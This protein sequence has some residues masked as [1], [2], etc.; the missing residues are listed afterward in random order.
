MVRE[1]ELRFDPD[2]PECFTEKFVFADFQIPS[3]QLDYRKLL[4]VPRLLWRPYTHAF[5][6]VVTYSRIDGDGVPCADTRAEGPTSYVVVKYPPLMYGEMFI[7]YKDP[8]DRELA[9]ALQEHA[10]RAGFFGYIAPADIRPGT[11]IWKQKIVPHIMSAF[12]MCVIWTNETPKGSGV[13]R[14][15]AI[16]RKRK[17]K[18]VLILDKAAAVPPGFKRTDVEHCRFRKKAADAD[19]GLIIEACRAFSVDSTLRSLPPNSVCRP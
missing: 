17:R 18:V 2:S 6:T 9:D 13:R 4:F 19:F 11:R 7:S 15:I 5:E 12:C 16:A 10:K 8:E 3:G 1:I 14:E